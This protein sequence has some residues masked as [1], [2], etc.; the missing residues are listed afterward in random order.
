MSTSTRTSQPLSEALGSELVTDGGFA[1]VTET[2]EYTSDFSAIPEIGGAPLTVTPNVTQDGVDDTAEVFADGADYDF[3]IYWATDFM[4]ASKILTKVTFDYWADAGC[5]VAYLGLGDRITNRVLATGG[6][7]IAVVEG[8][9]QTGKILYMY[10]PSDLYV[11]MN[12]YTTETGSTVDL[13]LNTKKIWLKNVTFHKVGFTSWTAGEGWIP[14]VSAQALAGKARKIAGT[15]SDLEQDVSAV[16]ASA[17]RTAHTT[18]RTAG[19][20]TAEVGGT[21]G[22]AR[23]TADTF[24][25]NVIAT[26][27]GNLKSAADASFAGT[28][29][30]VSCKE[31]TRRGIPD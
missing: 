3:A 6:S 25:D 31:I 16:A 4:S 26:T 10:E 5:G 27:T 23:A 20:E 13:L 19:S 1:A 8:S 12:G 22:A 21:S 9:W 28:I 7:N 14:G 2:L 17:Y 24:E 29:A 15:A 11:R 18:T 30:A